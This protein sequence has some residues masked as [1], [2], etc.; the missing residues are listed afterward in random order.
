[1]K[2]RHFLLR[3]VTY[4]GNPLRESCTNWKSQENFRWGCIKKYT[5]WRTDFGVKCSPHRVIQKSAKWVLYVLEGLRKSGV[6]KRKFD[7]LR[8]RGVAIL[9]FS[10]NRSYTCPFIFRALQDAVYRLSIGHLQAEI[11][12]TS[13]RPIWPTIEMHYQ[14]NSVKK[15]LQRSHLTLLHSKQDKH[16]TTLL[17]IS[18]LSTT[19]V[20][21][22]D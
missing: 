4:K 7:R 8:S 14:V 19:I 11:S 16:K 1:V 5:S 20:K 3:L 18:T 15:R 6:F 12:H 17:T 2:G 22:I 21:Y 9:D 10:E 13:F